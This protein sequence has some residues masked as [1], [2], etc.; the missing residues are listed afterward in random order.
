MLMSG[1]GFSRIE[2]GSDGSH[3]LKLSKVPRF[4]NFWYNFIRTK[5]LQV[6]I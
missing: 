5:K 4:A 3:V 1:P 6:C 2:R